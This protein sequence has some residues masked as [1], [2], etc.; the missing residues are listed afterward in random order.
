LAN[1][2]CLQS[3]CENARQVHRHC[4][5]LPRRG[6]CVVGNQRFAR[7]R[8]L[9]C[10]IHSRVRTDNREQFEQG[11]VLPGAKANLVVCSGKRALARE[12]P[13]GSVP[14]EAPPI[15]HSRP[16]NRQYLG[17]LGYKNELI[18][19]ILFTGNQCRSLHRECASDCGCMNE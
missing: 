9:H 10:A 13:A 5:F 14:D 4:R 8:D 17:I 15:L 1:L 11:S 7:Q 12:G 3:P 16:S 19:S 2:I 18:T 6:T